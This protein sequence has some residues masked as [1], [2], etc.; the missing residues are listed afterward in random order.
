MRQAHPFSEAVTKI[1]AER[2]GLEA[3][4]SSVCRLPPELCQ[5]VEALSR[6]FTRERSGLSFSYLD[7]ARA[8]RAY[9]SY[10]LP[11]NLA[12]V[13]TLLDEMLPELRRADPLHPLAVL[14]L[15]SGPGTASL[16]VR[17]WVHRAEGMSG[18]AVFC[19]A[20]DRSPQALQEG[21]QLWHAYSRLQPERRD[22]WESYECEL[23]RLTL[24][25][26]PRGAK[27]QPYD[28]IIIANA[29]GELFLSSKDAIAHRAALIRE[30]LD[31]LHEHG[32]IILI[33]PAL[34]DASRDLHRVRD[35]LLTQAACTVYSPCLH[36]RPC[37]ALAKDDDWCHEERLWSAP[38]FVKAIDE[39]VG[40]IKDALKFSY[41]ILRKDGRTI[42]PRAPGLYRVVSELREM[43]GEKR[44]WLCHEQGRPEVGQLDRMRSPA[45]AAFDEW[46][47]GA[48]VRISEIVRKKRKG[49]ES[50]VGRIGKESSVE[51]IR[52]V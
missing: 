16:G 1:I 21:N 49:K 22:R 46:H 38:P 13:Q 40:F 39:Q 17:D 20:V 9:L 5:G 50:T 34:R 4:R 45:N 2:V 47:R 26:L 37:P 29:L 41:L 48:I 32:A 35:L 24:A 27:S 19:V 44:A 6:L 36:E 43:K 7:D 18:T 11:V 52:P 31:A 8:R 14:D 12:K 51:I 23:E 28:L 33:E 42:V 3:P 15:G 10:Y 25:T 30:C